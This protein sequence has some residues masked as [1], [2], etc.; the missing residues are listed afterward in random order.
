MKKEYI[1]GILFALVFAVPAWFLGQ[2]FPIVGGPVFGILLGMLFAGLHRPQAFEAGI[3]FTGKKILQYAIILLGFEMNL[4]HVLEVGARSFSVMIFTLLTA[5]FVALTVG[6]LLK[7]ERSTTTLIGAG[8]AICGGSAI[9]AVAPVIGAKDKDIAFSISTIFLF[10]VLAVFIF[11]FLGHL[12]NMSDF[13]FGMWAGTAV[14]DT[15]SVVAAGYSYSEE[16][17]G[18]ATIVK[19]TRALMIVPVCLF[20]AFLTAREKSGQGGGFSLGRIFPW[21]ILWFVVASIVNTTGFLPAA[22]S[23]MLGSLG[24]FAIVLAMCAIGLNTRLMELVK[25]GLA[26]IALGFCCWAAVACMSLFVQYVT[27]IL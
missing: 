21:F 17:G 16:A 1:R 15:S 7:L 8:T 6:R 12:M 22:L 9:A 26:P 20:F 27:G 18:F 10:N 11:P 5:F 19:L 13:G 24:K 3:S 23:H 14:N 25:H 2:Q 4:F